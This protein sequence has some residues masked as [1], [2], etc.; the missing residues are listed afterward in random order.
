MKQLAKYLSNYRYEIL[1]ELNGDCFIKDTETNKHYFKQKFFASN[2]K[3]F[4]NIII[5]NWNRK[6]TIYL[7][8]IILSIIS[9]IIIIVYLDDIFRV[10][11]SLHMI[12]QSCV[13][14]CINLILHEIGHAITLKYFGKKRGS[15]KFRFHFIFLTIF[16]D[17]S[18]CYLSLNSLTRLT[19]YDLM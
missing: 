10:K 11:M 9:A 16:A 1:E 8:F 13:F 17:I 6:D 15:Y 12:F 18:E 2:R 14:L 4:E 7:F 5:L 19:I 3:D